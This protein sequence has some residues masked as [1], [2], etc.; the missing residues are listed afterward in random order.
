[1]V[2]AI[3]LFAVGC[4]A[5]WAG[6]AALQGN[7]HLVETAAGIGTQTPWNSPAGYTIAA[8]LL[9][10][11]LVLLIV[12]LSPG[13]Y[14]AIRLNDPAANSTSRARSSSPVEYVIGRRAL[15]RLART[16]AEQVDGVESAAV[17]VSPRRIDVAVDT[18]LVDATDLQETVRQRLEQALA[19]LDPATRPR[20]GVKTTTRTLD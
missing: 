12:A 13:K 6:V 4:A 7:T 16:R 18:Y 15:G 11:G 1:M 2:T 17:K 9:V 8:V 14:N 20:I 5:V 3:I 10:V 19:D